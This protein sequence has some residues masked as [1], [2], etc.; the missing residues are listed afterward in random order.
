MTRLLFLT[1]PG[2]A[3]TTT[4]A[5]ATALRAA[6]DGSRVL[7]F[8]VD[9]AGALEA[10][11]D[12]AQYQALPRDDAETSGSGELATPHLT[13]RGFDHQAATETALEALAHHLAVPFAAAGFSAPAPSEIGPVPGLPDVLAVREIAAAVASGDWDAVIVDGPPLRAA[14]DLLSWPETAAAALRR[15]RPVEGQAARALRPLLAG[16]VGLPSPFAAV[17]KWTEEAAAEIA[18]VRDVLAGDHSVIRLVTSDARS[19]QP[20]QRVADSVLALQGLRSDKLVAVARHAGEPV[21]LEA[22]AALADA[23]YGDADPIPAPAAPP[24]PVLDPDGAGYR[25]DLPLPGVT[26]DAL[27]LVRSGDELVVT[28]SAEGVAGHRRAFV[29]PAALRRC[30][31]ASARLEDGLLRIGF[32][33]DETLWPDGLLPDQG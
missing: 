22:L 9:D 12:G 4:L 7:L 5:A 8:G 30:R 15:L 19:A 13:V 6:R 25:Y 24:R 14:L 23:V 18:G 31:I 3:G 28:V 2:G 10:V 27:G 20:I 11:L 29:L 33:P 1:G 21:G 26:R 17:T 32:K 16:L